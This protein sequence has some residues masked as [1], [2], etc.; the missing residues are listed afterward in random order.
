MSTQKT[1]RPAVRGRGASV[2]LWAM[3]VSAAVHLLALTTLG[4]FHFSRRAD[5]TD[6]KPADI[7]VHAIEQVIEQ[8]EPKPKPKIETPPAPTVKASVPEPAPLL[9]LPE[10][11]VPEPTAAAEATPR[12]AEST[13]FFGAETAARRVCYVVDGSGSMN[14]LMYLVR[15]QMRESILRLTQEQSF[16]VLFFMRDGRL[17]EAFAGRLEAAGPAAKTEALNLLGRIR[18][19]GQTDAEQA[20]E[21]AMRLRDK[22]QMRPEVVF[23]L[24][25]GF[26]LMD[27]VGDD[28]I[29]RVV[30]LRKNLAPQVIVHTIGIY[31]AREDSVI[32]SQ[33]AEVCGGRYIEVN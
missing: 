21:A 17:S 3:G 11:P 33:L 10:I 19:E 5:A 9:P 22:A 16:N 23:F 12:P 32:L 15:E 27:G 29:R 28:F 6:A 25:D 4:A 24:T 1:I 14:G 30:N 7:S 18:P 31:P 2:R 13:L 20:L 26:D 8:P